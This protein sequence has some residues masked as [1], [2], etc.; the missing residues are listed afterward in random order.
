MLDQ[1]KDEVFTVT[2]PEMSNQQMNDLQKSISAF[3]AKKFY[4]IY[5]HEISENIMTLKKKTIL[6]TLR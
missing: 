4:V 5:D 6:C 1:Y 3:L 2:M